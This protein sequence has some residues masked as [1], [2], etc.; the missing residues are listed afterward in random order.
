MMSH[1]ERG[2]LRR[3]RTDG[4]KRRREGEMRLFVSSQQLTVQASLSAFNGG[5]ILPAATDNQECCFIIFTPSGKHVIFLLTR[6]RR[7]HLRA[8]VPVCLFVTSAD[9]HLSSWRINKVFYNKL[10]FSFLRACRRT[11]VFCSVSGIFTKR[12]FQ[13][14]P[15]RR[16]SLSEVWGRL[17]D[18]HKKKKVS[19]PHGTDK[20][21]F[22]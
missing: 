20:S 17:D 3:R 14:Y 19:A 10:C 6:D 2:L 22:L 7:A 12:Y 9:C 18:K 11:S 1:C 16:R 5:L 13:I 4:G 8:S 21:Y 15:W